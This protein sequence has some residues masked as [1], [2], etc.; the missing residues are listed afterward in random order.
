MSVERRLPLIFSSDNP[1]KMFQ[2][3]DSRSARNVCNSLILFK[4]VNIQSAQNVPSSL[5]Q[6]NYREMR[7][8]DN[9]LNRLDY[10]E[11][12]EA[13]IACRASLFAWLDVVVLPSCAGLV[14]IGF[15][16]K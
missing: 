5:S 10:N 4:T 16:R 9:P 2:T 8:L 14:A 11:S 13:D 3:G 1:L 6:L 12:L 15:D 7:E